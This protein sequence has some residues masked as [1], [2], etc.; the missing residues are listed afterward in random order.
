MNLEGS[1]HGLFEGIIYTKIIKNATT[2]PTKIAGSPINVSTKYLQD[3]STESYTS[4]HSHHGLAIGS[5][6]LGLRGS[7]CVC[8]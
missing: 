2:K 5:S 1:G 3:T 4:W 7:L 6:K 8:R